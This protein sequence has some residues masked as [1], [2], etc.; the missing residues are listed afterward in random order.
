MRQQFHVEKQLTIVVARIFYSMIFL[1]AGLADFSANTVSYAAS[2]G[3]P[4]ASVLVPI[5][6]VM[7]IAGA[8]SIILGYK[9][10]IG[11]I[12]IVLFLLPVT[13]AMHP[14]WKVADTKAHQVAMTEFLKNISLLGGALYIFIA[15]A[16]DYS[17]DARNRTKIL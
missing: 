5:S 9:I 2:Q 11:A 7:A 10:K 1:I 4:I 17:L 3:V 12:L 16:G 13:F 6:G 14:F 15:G 8:V